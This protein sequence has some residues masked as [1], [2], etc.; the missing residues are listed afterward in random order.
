MLGPP[1][2]TGKPCFSGFALSPPQDPPKTGF[3]T[4]KVGFRGVLGDPPWGSFFGV[5]GVVFSGSGGPRGRGWGSPKTGVPGVQKSGIR[6]VPRGWSE[7]RFFS[8]PNNFLGFWGSRGVFWG[9]PRFLAKSGGR[10]P[11]VAI[12]DFRGSEP[13]FSVFRKTPVFGVGPP[14]LAKSGRGTRRSEKK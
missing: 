3:R 12:S 10:P 7:N 2:V 5:P 1:F 11:K 14:D 6:G 4:Q 9:N 13:F 8:V